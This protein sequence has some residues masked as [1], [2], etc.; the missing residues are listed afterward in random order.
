MSGRE[1]GFTLIE[2]LVAAVVFALVMLLAGEGM[3]LALSG[4]Q[5]AR[6]QSEDSA[7]LIAVQ[8]LLFRLLA[9]PW[10]AVVPG[11][12]GLALAFDARPTRL[13]LVA[14]LPTDGGRQAAVE[15]RVENGA[16]VLVHAPLDPGSR[17]P[18]A[19][20]ATG[21]RLVLVEGIRGGGFAYWGEVRKGAGAAWHST[22]SDP[23]ALPRLVR[24]R[25]SFAPT[26]RRRWPDLVAAPKVVT[27]V[28]F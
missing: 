22:W 1:S 8:R 18:F 5:A 17:T 20:L 3:R 19:A 11:G 9:E 6:L 12:G 4:W 21:R 26:D 2:V 27:P 15:L 25:L 10:P 14:L 7:E 23:H 16:L 28:T 24:L 13:R